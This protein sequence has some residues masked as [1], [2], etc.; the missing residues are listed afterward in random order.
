M[1]K[2]PSNRWESTGP[3][4]KSSHA[5]RIGCNSGFPSW[6]CSGSGVP[7]LSEPSIVE[8]WQHQPCLS[9]EIPCVSSKRQRWT[10]VFFKMEHLH[11]PV[12]LGSQMSLLDVAVSCVLCGWRPNFI[13]HVGAEL[14]LETNPQSPSRFWKK[15]THTHTIAASQAPLD[16][17]D[18]PKAMDKF[19]QKNYIIKPSTVELYMLGPAL[20]ANL[21]KSK[22]YHHLLLVWESLPGRL[23]GPVYIYTYGKMI[24]RFIYIYTLY[25]YRD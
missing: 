17:H 9:S 19:N 13:G 23:Q 7:W 4:W 21:K 10:C 15:S 25:L 16:A 2:N 24:G 11:I 18:I 1:G 5:H 22:N 8:W 6:W 20:L 12:S 14:W 3:G